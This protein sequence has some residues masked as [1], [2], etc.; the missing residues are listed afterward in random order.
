M[1]PVPFRLSPSGWLPVDT[2]YSRVLKNTLLGVGW[3]ADQELHCSRD[4]LNVFSTRLFSSLRL[5]FA[6][7]AELRAL[8]LAGSLK[9]P[10]NPKRGPGKA[11]QHEV[12]PV[13][14]LSLVNELHVICAIRGAVRRRV[15]S[16][17]QDR[18]GLPSHTLQTYLRCPEAPELEGLTPNMWAVL[19]LLSGELQVLE[20]WLNLVKCVLALLQ[21]TPHWPVLRALPC[22]EGEL[23]DLDEEQELDD[24]ATRQAVRGFGREQWLNVIEETTGDEVAFSW[25]L[26]QSWLPLLM[27]PPE[28]QPDTRASVHITSQEDSEEMEK[29]I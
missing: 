24:E 11:K 9:P 13:Q 29:I 28:P 22:L 1:A 18:K 8:E 19:H 12:P 4:L 20:W 6:S 17:Q 3:A 2:A 23:L 16:L 5:S 10:S 15:K 27:K 7:A 26:V 25:Y 14:A 21:C